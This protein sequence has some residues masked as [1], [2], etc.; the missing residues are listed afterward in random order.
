MN[1][2]YTDANNDPVGPVSEEELHA[3]HRNGTI[4]TDTMVIPDGA[5]EWQPYLVFA[6]SPSPPFRPPAPPGLGVPRPHASSPSPLF[7]SAP[8]P[9]SPQPLQTRP[10]ALH[11]PSATK[12]CP[13]CAEEISP[14]AKK[15]K[16]CGETLDLALRAAQEAQ[17]M[18]T[19]QPAVYM[20]A[21]GG[22]A[23]R[24]PIVVIQ[25]HNFP[26]GIH[27]VVTFLSLGMWFPIWMC[28]YLF[29]NHNY[30]D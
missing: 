23:G 27:L 18:S 9:S 15:C 12:T 21:G 1:Y 3:L 16:H 7:R 5:V 6:P 26:H 14:A 10:S 2:H 24:S 20:N 4:S 13:F 8:P 28:H 11:I 19:R 17:R 29:R 22:G 30:Y 25:K